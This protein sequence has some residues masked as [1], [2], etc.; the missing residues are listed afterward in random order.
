MEPAKRVVV[1]TFAQYARTVV[2]AVISLYSTRI[3]LQALGKSDYGL[4]MLVGGVVAMLG[5]LTNAMQVTTQRHLSYSQGQG[6]L[7]QVRRVFVNSLMLHLS[8]GAGLAVLMAACEPLIFPRLNIDPQRLDEASAVYFIVVGMLLLSFLAA[9]FRS[10]FVSREN[11][12]YISIVDVL[13]GVLKLVLVLMLAFFGGDRLVAY[14]WIMFGVQVFNLVA[15]SAYAAVRFEECRIVPRCG[16]LD[17]RMMRSLLGYGGWIVYTMGCTIGRT[18]GLSVLLNHFFGTVI[19][20]A[21]GIA[22]Q[23]SGTVLFVSQSVCNAI[24]PQII[25]AESTNNRQRMLQLAET[26]SKYASLLLAMVALPLIFEMRSIL[27]LWLGDEHVPEHTVMF[28]QFVL[29]ASLCDQLTIGLWTA[30]QA[31]GRIRNYSLLISTLKILMLPAAYGCLKLGL[32]VDSVMW[33]FAGFELLAALTRLPFLKATAGLSVRHFAARVF[34]RVLPS[35]AVLTLVCYVMTE[36]VSAFDFRFAVTFA[37]S[38]VLNL[39]VVWFCSCR[40]E[41][42]MAMRRIV[43]RRRAVA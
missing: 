29:I 4:Y 20:S 23:V 43:A 13:D 38:F 25:K 32:P 37:V 27:G 42:R 2:N 33:C 39:V 14:A 19:N 21:Y 8:L 24:S 9:P 36:R 22:M 6:D 40:E 12:V 5:F 18:Q 17:R 41:E 26:T 35:L 1:N 11:I 3:V 28:C 15:L 7:R 10:L 31:I 16:D 34:L 30:N